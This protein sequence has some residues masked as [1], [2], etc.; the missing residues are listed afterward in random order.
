MVAVP[1]TVR[2]LKVPDIHYPD[3][4][5]Y[6]ADG[7]GISAALMASDNSIC[8]LALADA[9]SAHNAHHNRRLKTQQRRIEVIGLKY[10]ATQNVR[11]TFT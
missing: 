10:S 9:Q 11:A 1:L 7:G 3:G 2:E 6:K 8:R 5:D 4:V